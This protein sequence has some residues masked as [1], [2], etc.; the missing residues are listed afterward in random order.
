MGAGVIS[1]SR[2]LVSQKS[3]KE[4]EE[5]EDEDDEDDPFPL[6]PLPFPAASST[7]N[8]DDDEDRLEKKNLEHNWCLSLKVAGIGS[9]TMGLA[10][11]S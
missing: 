2:R 9:G 4:E 10:G 11:K 7:A 8:D 1:S 6:P 5:E 3:A